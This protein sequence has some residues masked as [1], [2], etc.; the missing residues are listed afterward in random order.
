MQSTAGLARNALLLLLG[1]GAM[2]AWQARRPAAPTRPAA[3]AHMAA[4][5]A[6]DSVGD[7]GEADGTRAARAADGLFYV[8]ARVNGRPVRFLVDTG[9]S[10]V[11][12]TPAD[13]AA[14]GVAPAP[15]RFDAHVLT[16]AG[17]APMAWATLNEVR[18]AGRAV[19]GVRAA[20]VRDGLAVSLLGQN[21][22]ARLG[23][24]RMEGDQ[25]E[26]R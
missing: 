10:V 11:V 25:L 14:V 6:D 24:V 17:N 16:A 5:A 19:R 3:S 8:H 13:A 26:L 20:V 12:L 18:L 15:D 2:A 1:V 22:L 23:S 4:I 21:M 9:A 7:D